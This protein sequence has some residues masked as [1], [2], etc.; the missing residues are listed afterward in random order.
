MTVYSTRT[1]KRDTRL[2]HY[3]F[4]GSDETAAARLPRIAEIH[5]FHRR[6]SPKIYFAFPCS[7]QTG[8]K[9][10]RAEIGSA[11]SEYYG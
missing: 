4:E 7:V 5:T 6:Q 1:V 8:H 11:N 3:L 10:I 2:R 9:Y